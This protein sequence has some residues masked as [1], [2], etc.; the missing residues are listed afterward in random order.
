MT[1]PTDPVFAVGEPGPVLF[2]LVRLLSRQPGGRGSAGR[3]GD[4]TRQRMASIQVVQ[5]V[6]ACTG[7]ITIGTVARYLRIEHSTA[8][9][10]V[11]D[12]LR[13]GYVRGQPSKVDA[14]RISLELTDVGR[15]LLLGT[16]AYQR[17]VFEQATADWSEKDRETFG[18]LL[19]VF[20]R[21]ILHEDDP[22]P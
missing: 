16:K 1:E 3:Q 14:R 18:R 20:A 11:G 2:R 19:V 15:E 10:L 13:A 5:A 7:E 6:G 4:A 9:R 17:E 12:T 22:S 21:S 8:S